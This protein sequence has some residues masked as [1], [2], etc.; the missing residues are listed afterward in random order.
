MVYHELFPNAVRPHYC[1][2]ASVGR[3]MQDTGTLEMNGQYTLR[4]PSICTP[5]F[6]EDI[7]QLFE[8]NPSTSTRAVV[9]ELSVD[10]RRCRT[11][12]AHSIF[13]LSI[14]RRCRLLAP[15]ISFFETNLC[16]GLCGR[17]QRSPNFLHFFF[18]SNEA[19][20]TREGVCNTNKS[21]LGGNKPSCCIC[22]LPPPT[23]ICA[24]IFNLAFR[25]NPQLNAQIYRLFLVKTLP[26]LLEKIP[27]GLG[28]D[29]YF[30]YDGDSAHFSCHFR[31]R[32][33]TTYKDRCVGRGGPVPWPLRSAYRTS[34][35]FFLW[36]YMK[37]L[38]THRQFIPKRILL[39][40]SLRQQQTSGRN[41]ASMKAHHLFFV[42]VSGHNFECTL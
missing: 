17:V 1:K 8:V 14:G 16:V 20:F 11:F 18:F 27:L 37:T 22:S 39:L 21:C 23:T 10:L 26:E 3:R 5:T 40:L 28:R 42:V 7:L 6:D 34:L 35:D 32:P 30:Q 25:V 41:L 24:W 9:H 13:M 38:F 29:M 12:Y 2:F 15:T 36:Y 4:G 31:E 19:C 33:T